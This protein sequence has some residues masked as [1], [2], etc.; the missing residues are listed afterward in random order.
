MQTIF[1]LLAPT[2]LSMLELLQ[3]A[4]NYSKEFNI[5]F[6]SSKTVHIVFGDNICQ[7]NKIRLMGEEIKQ[8]DNDKHLQVGNVIG[9]NTGKQ[10][11]DNVMRDFFT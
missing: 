1:T 9:T 11:I 2:K 5:Q 10:V 3:I 7:H 8:V 4:E 6:N